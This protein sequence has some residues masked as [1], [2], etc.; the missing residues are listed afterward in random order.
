MCLSDV[1]LPNTRENLYFF[2][3]LKNDTLYAHKI[4]LER[5]CSM[6]Q[7]CVWCVCVCVRACVVRARLC[8][9]TARVGSFKSK[10]M[11]LGF[12]SPNKNGKKA[13]EQ[14]AT[15]REEELGRRRRTASEK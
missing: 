2:S 13:S 11:C 12:Q 5:Y 4:K 10:H 15:H 14:S 6:Y 3:L 8:E 9:E 1:F 7:L